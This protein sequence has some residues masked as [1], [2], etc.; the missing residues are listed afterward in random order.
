MRYRKVTFDQKYISGCLD[1]PRVLLLGPTGISAVS[2]GGT[3][4]HSALGIKPF[5]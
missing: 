3:A 4:I 2:L 5:E 1:K